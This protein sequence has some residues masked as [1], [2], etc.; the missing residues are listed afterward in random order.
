ME[1]RRKVKITNFKEY[2]KLSNQ[3]RRETDKAIEVNM[4]EI[5]DGIMD[6]Q[7]KGGYDHLSE[8]TTVRRNYQ[9]VWN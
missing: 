7:R 1:E 6:P 8:G 9:N 3:L 4:G 2:R 5:C